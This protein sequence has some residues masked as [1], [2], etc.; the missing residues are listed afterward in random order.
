VLKGAPFLVDG[1]LAVGAVF[2]WFGIHLK[3]PLHE[4]DDPVFLNAAFCVNGEFVLAVFVKGAGA[5]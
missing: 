1:N 4:V 5:K 2:L 3:L